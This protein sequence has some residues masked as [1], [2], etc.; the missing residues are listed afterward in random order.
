MSLFK[1]F[2]APPTVPDFAEDLAVMGATITADSKA[3]AESR[4][5]IKTASNVGL[6]SQFTKRIPLLGAVVTAG[7]AIKEVASLAWD[8]DWEAAGYATVLG[9]AETSGACIPAF[10]LG[11]DAAREAGYQFLS[12]VGANLDNVQYSG[13][14]TLM[15]AAVNGFEAEDVDALQVDVVPVDEKPVVQAATPAEGKGCLASVWD[16]AMDND[17]PSKIEAGPEVDVLEA[18]LHP[19]TSFAESVS[20]TE[21]AALSGGFNERSSTGLAQTPAAKPDMVFRV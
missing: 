6:V 14:R 9:V 13:A 21:Q 10:G 5:V 3:I 8:G 16:W 17:D 2:F 19:N 7:F 20:P 15:G 4:G 11:G 12:A 18:D 1:D